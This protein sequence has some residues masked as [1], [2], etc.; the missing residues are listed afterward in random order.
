[1]AGVW[2][3]EQKQDGARVPLTDDGRTHAVRVEMGT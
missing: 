3:D 2:L 1:V